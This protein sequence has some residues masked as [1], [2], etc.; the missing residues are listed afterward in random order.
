LF[1]LLQNVWHRLKPG[2]VKWQN[3]EDDRG[4]VY[5]NWR[6]HRQHASA[7]IDTLP[8]LTSAL[9]RFGENLNLIIEE[10]HK[11]SLQIYFVNQAALWKDSMTDDELK[12]LWMGGIG[13]YQQ[14]AGHAYYSP[15]VLRKGLDMYNEK[16]KDLCRENGIAMIDIDSNLPRDATIFYDDCHFT[17]A[18]ARRVAEIVYRSLPH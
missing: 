1:Y 4:E 18:G 12:L 11:Q 10:A 13:N 5:K 9:N 17:E 3:I 16:L 15:N 6:E 2:G 7:I 14:E 8:D